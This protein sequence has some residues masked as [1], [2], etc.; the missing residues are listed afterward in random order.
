MRRWCIILLFLIGLTLQGGCQEQGEFAID[1]GTERV[2]NAEEQAKEDKSTTETQFKVPKI[3]FMRVSHDFG[4]ISPGSR[5]KTTF[6]FK[7]IGTEV[8]KISKVKT[9]CGCTVPELA[10]K[11]YLPGETGVITVT[12]KA[13]KRPGRVSKHL[14]V[15]SNDKTNPEVKLALKG[16]IVVKVDYKPKRITLSLRD[17][18]G[19]CPQIVLNSLDGQEFSIKKFQSK[20][21]CISADIDPTVSKTGF[22]ITPKVDMERL[23]KVSKGTIFIELTHP[24]LDKAMITFDTLSE[25]KINPASLALFNAEP[26]KPV[27]RELW[28]LN[29]YKE[30][31]EVESVSSKNGFIKVLNEEKIDSRYKFDLEITPPAK[32]KNKRNFSDVLFIKIQG[33]KEFEIKCRGY[34]SV[35]KN[36]KSG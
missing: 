24:E 34:Y 33:G 29:N 36:R 28:L 26:N 4:D 32:E 10:K 9:T 27:E 6:T 5:N 22:T 23:G 1:D 17:E 25:F 8:L 7:N 14:T 19:G 12:Y 18:N 30:D 13:N 21:A 11:H 35:K 16:T 2:L 20:P 3:D 15:K 31:F